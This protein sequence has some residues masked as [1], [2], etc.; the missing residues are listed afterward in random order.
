MQRRPQFLTPLFH[1]GLCALLLLGTTTFVR[2][3]DAKVDP[4]GTWTWTVPNRQ[5]GAERKLTLKLK[6]E[7]DKL[8]GKLSSPGR[9]GQTSEIEIKEGKIKGD[10]FS[11]I[12]SRERGGN[13]MVTKYTGK[14]VD[15]KIKGKQVTENNGKAG[16]ERDWEAKP[17]KKDAP[18]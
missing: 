13:T 5:S 7:G 17:E 14:I 18:K 11:F 9:G 15:G 16:A 4:A 3:A 12:V 10:E 6:V 1:T 2:A 8:T